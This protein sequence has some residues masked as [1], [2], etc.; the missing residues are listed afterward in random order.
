MEERQAGTA[1][2]L[3]PSACSEKFV[4]LILGYSQEKKSLDQQFSNQATRAVLQY[5]RKREQL[6][7]H[8]PEFTWR[9]CSMRII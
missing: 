7:E 2:N 5:S 3:I 1:S 6:Q 9:M 4:S 8:E